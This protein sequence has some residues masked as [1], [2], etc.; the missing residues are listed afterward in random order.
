MNK[1]IIC[2]INMGS[3]LQDIVIQQ[4]NNIIGKYKLSMQEIPNFIY[5]HKDIS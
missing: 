5:E 1:K 2:N 3:L 4:G